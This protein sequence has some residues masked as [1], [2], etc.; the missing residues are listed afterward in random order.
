[1]P[2][3]LSSVKF[4]L[5]VGSIVI[6]AG[7]AYAFWKDVKRGIYDSVFAD[8]AQEVADENQRV[9]D[10]LKHQIDLSRQVF[11]AMT[12]NTDKFNGDQRDITDRANSAEDGTI[13][14]SVKEILR[15]LREVQQREGL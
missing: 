12:D 2:A 13:S 14:E 11:D 10:S 9:I 7:L 1:M 8:V 3:F 15:G 5:I 6:V 4:Y